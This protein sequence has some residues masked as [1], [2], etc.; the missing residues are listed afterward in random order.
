[1][2]SKQQFEAPLESPPGVL[3]FVS[4][5]IFIICGILP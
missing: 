4:I 2:P 5:I 1:M 3:Q